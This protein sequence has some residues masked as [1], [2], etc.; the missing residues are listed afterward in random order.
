MN[1]ISIK[2]ISYVFS[3]ALCAVAAVAAQ[4]QTY[5]TK[6]IRIIVP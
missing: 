6:P 4:A 5:P 3:V 1:K 2:T